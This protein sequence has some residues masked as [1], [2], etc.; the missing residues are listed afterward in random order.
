MV[1]IDLRPA[2]S[3]A[4]WK[5]ALDLGGTYAKGTA[6]YSPHTNTRPRRVVQTIRKA[7]KRT[8]IDQQKNWDELLFVLGKTIFAKKR[9]REY[10]AYEMLFAASLDWVFSPA[11]ISIQTTASSSGEFHQDLSRELGIVETIVIS[12]QRAERS[13]LKRQILNNPYTID[14][15]VLVKKRPFMLVKRNWQQ[16]GWGLAK[17]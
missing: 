5:I 16:D 2:C 9:K 12:S 13:S 6:Q 17:L 15:R 4:A 10:S 14:D 11:I 3:S 7:I 1:L 8:V